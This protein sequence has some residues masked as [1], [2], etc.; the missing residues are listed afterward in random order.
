MTKE[1]YLGAEL[2]SGPSACSDFGGEVCVCVGT[3][4]LLSR[5]RGLGIQY[6]PSWVVECKSTGVSYHSD[7]VVSTLSGLN[8]TKA[9]VTK[10]FT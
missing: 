4:R 2:R 7:E 9:T 10:Y 3:C 5:E 8:L 1:G 6:D